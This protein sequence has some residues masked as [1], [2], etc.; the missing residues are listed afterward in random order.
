[1]NRQKYLNAW[2]ENNI[3]AFPRS[4][5]VNNFPASVQAYPDVDFIPIDMSVVFTASL[6][7]GRFNL[8]DRIKI[9][10]GP[11]EVLILMVIGAVP[12]AGDSMLFGF[13]IDGGRIVLLGV[14][15]GTL[16]LVNSSFRALVDFLYAFACFID[17][18]TGI[19]GR[20]ERATLL[21]KTLMA[22]D[23]SA[24]SSSESWWAVSLSKLGAI[25]VP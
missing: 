17:E 2:G 14:D 4:Q 21:R 12:A 1:M 18:D 11:N 16:E 22:V 13:D 23:A 5:W 3:T 9:E 25:A 6:E 10:V 20:S 7:G 15:T 24:F 8:Y 19:S